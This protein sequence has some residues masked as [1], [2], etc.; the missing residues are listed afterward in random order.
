MKSIN[1]GREHS[2]GPLAPITAPTGADGKKLEAKKIVVYPS[3]HIHGEE[4]HVG[5]LKHLPAKGVMHVHYHIHSHEV[6]NSADGKGKEHHMELKIHKITHVESGKK[7]PTG[8][9]ALNSLAKTAKGAPAGADGDND[10][11]EY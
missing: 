4:K 2:S 9:E 7:E 3:L 5:D 1:L 6:R 10:G 11:D 8:E